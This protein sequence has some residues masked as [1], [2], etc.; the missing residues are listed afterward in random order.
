MRV[1][2][3]KSGC[4]TTGT[5]QYGV[6]KTVVLLF[7]STLFLS[8]VLL[9]VL[10]PM[11]AK[12]ILPTLGGAPAVWN[13]CIVFYQTTLLAGYLYAHIATRWLTVERQVL[14]HAVLLLL[15]AAVLP[16]RIISAS[17]L[18]TTGNPTTWLFLTLAL[19]VG[20]PFF[21][22]AAGAPLLQHWFAATP[23]PSRRDP[24]FL[25]AACNLGSLVGLLAYPLALEPNLRLAGQS[26][27]WA[28][29]Y[30]A[31]VA[32]TVS[33]AG[34][35][36]RGGS[37][38]AVHGKEQERGSPD[39]DEIAASLHD[40]P[41]NRD[42]LRWFVLSCVPSSLMLSVTTY[43]STD[44]AS[45]PLLW[46][47][48][49]GLYLL[50]FI[51]AFRRTQVLP[52]RW[53]Y[54][55]LTVAGVAALVSILGGLNSPEALIIL[56]HLVAF[57]LAALACHGQLAR[58][59]PYVTHLTD[60][61]LWISIGGTAGGLFNVLL[62][63]VLF[64]TAIE[65][66]LFLVAAV[67]TWPIDTLHDVRRK[68]LFLDVAA[69]TLGLGLVLL[70]SSAACSLGL[71]PHA[72][73]VSAGAFGVPLLAFGAR[74]RDIR[75]AGLGAAALL[76]AAVMVTATGAGV[77]PVGRN[78]F[79]IHR[80]RTST[81]GRFREFLSGTTVHGMQSLSS[82]M[83]SDPL[84]YYHRQGPFGQIFEVASRRHPELTVAAL[85]LGIGSMAC[86]ALPGQHWTFYEIDSEVVRVARDTR[87]FTLMRDCAADAAVVLGDAR[88]SL[89]NAPD[90]AYDLIAVDVFSS[91]AIP[92][93][94]LTREALAL[95]LRKLTPSG[96]IAVHISNRHFALDPVIGALAADAGI[97]AMI[98]TDGPE[99]GEGWQDGRLPSV[100][101]ALS[102]AVP[103]LEPLAAD[104][105]WSRPAVP[106]GFPVWTDDYSNLLGVIRW[107]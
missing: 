59:R 21:V 8:S 99:K 66:P 48:P 61:Y 57:S 107:R 81:D 68:P 6:E 77:I 74:R 102:R 38:H 63:P 16:V 95:Y 53:V 70:V 37:R 13:T 91:D 22:V 90:S 24:F 80:I 71:S 29:V 75:H 14:V 45:M 82:G 97:H 96:V 100:W 105:R 31:L 94:L 11:F 40:A 35:I 73:V 92:I 106:S 27:F 18:P 17:A 87:Y 55:G 52:E 19:S 5:V 104:A 88:L 83:M 9:F 54:T 60:F 32:G 1:T 42:R 76:L 2:S 64:K 50:T 98:R 72:P 12:M 39:V 85:G 49:L 44:I 15:A 28:I 101:V 46:V 20:P 36:W 93:H 4:L 58:R 23:H 89:A 84:S 56:L 78:F 34:V 69:V 51:L 67:V 86:Y 26:L 43:I 25:Y 10:E 3:A 65:Y 41:T 62:A 7:A 30:A 33:C 79:G 47:I 103:N